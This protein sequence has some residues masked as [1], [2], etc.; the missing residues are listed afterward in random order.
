M[1][2]LTELTLHAG[3]CSLVAVIVVT[4]LGLA[5]RINQEKLAK[6]LALTSAQAKSEFLANMSHE[7]R[8]PM[9]AIVGFTELTLG[10]SVTREQR[11]YLERIQ[12][13]S[14]N[15][16]GIIN[17]ILDFSKVEAG[18]LELEYRAL[19]VVAMFDNIQSMFLQRVDE[20][21]LKLS[22]HISPDVPLR[23][24]GDPLRLNQVLINLVGNAIKFTEQGEIRMSASVVEESDA[25]VT[26]QVSVADTGIGISQQQQQRL[27][28]SFTQADTSTTRQFGGTGLGLAITRQLVHLMEG[29]I[30][31]DSQPGRGSTFTFTMV[32]RRPGSAEHDYRSK[33]C[34][35][36]SDGAEPMLTEWFTDTLNQVTTIEPLE[37]MRSGLPNSELTVL[38]ESGATPNTLISELR[39]HAETGRVIVISQAKTGPL[40]SV[41]SSASLKS[42][43]LDELEAFI[44]DI[45][46]RPAANQLHLI[47]IKTYGEAPPWEGARV[48]LVED[49]TVNQMLATAMLKK[50][51]MSVEVASNGLD[52]IHAL[53][54]RAFDVVLMD[55]QM[56]V[57]DGL[58][59]T[60]SIRDVL[61]FQDLPVIAMTANAMRGDRERCIDAGMNDYITKPIDREAMYRTIGR[62]LN[63]H[64]TT[65]H[66]VH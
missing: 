34:T 61:Q 66:A 27:F 56:P 26:V 57:M 5:K 42:L 4:S 2:P 32:L 1:L 54:D 13:A 30:W 8:T 33:P 31:V 16:L 64:E 62:W 44:E 63:Q 65:E 38:I 59:A 43:Y 24:I 14:G 40:I 41:L 9:N 23:L 19:S 20:Q 48:L 45:D 60:R 12:V 58:E 29:Q 53:T 7:I 28:D 21:G 22:A 39:T 3:D 18:E 35:L 49:N 47:T 25:G 17:D 6:E 50:G 46:E 10:T 36:I 51:N 15:L 55:V 52:A 11:D 37:A